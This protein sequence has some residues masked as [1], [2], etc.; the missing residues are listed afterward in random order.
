MSI[1]LSVE[2][3]TKICSVALHQEGCLLACQELFLERSH[4]SQLVVLINDILKQCNLSF[5]EVSAF[6]VSIGPG[7]YTGL[8]IGTSTVKGYVMVLINP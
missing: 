3:S 7:S 5:D 8:R 4:S 2:T 6:A 1:I